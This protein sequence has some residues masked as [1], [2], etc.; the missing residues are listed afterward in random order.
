MLGRFFKALFRHAPVDKPRDGSL[1]STDPEQWKKAT[2][3]AER[4]PLARHA[5]ILS[6][7]IAIGGEPLS[8]LVARCFADAG[9]YIPPV[10]LL[11]RLHASLNLMQYFVC[12]LEVPGARAECG[13][14]AGTSALVCCRAARAQR[15]D[16]DG[17]D[18]HLID[19]FQGMA[20]PAAE[21]F[22]VVENDP[23]SRAG[24]KALKTVYPKGAM[25]APVELV[26]R[27]MA[28]FP[29][30]GIHE[31]WIPEVFGELPDTAWAFVHVDVD[32][33]KPTRAALEYFYPRLSDGGIIICDDYGSPRCP[34]AK[35]AWDE[36][37]GD[38]IPYVVLDTG[39]SVIIRE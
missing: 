31:G 35:A 9:A 13:V 25:A 17:S 20:E 15:P 6:Q 23:R 18:L 5:E 4:A 37:C 21:D 27:A 39:Q 2:I 33:Y 11:H 8:E 29:G 19:S 3:M 12:S 32:Q 22:F 26:R 34:G 30:T 1:A 24:G 16:F 7:G 38:A 14:F 36:F 28:E 10:K